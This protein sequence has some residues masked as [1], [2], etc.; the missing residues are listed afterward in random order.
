MKHSVTQVISEKIL[1]WAVKRIEKRKRER[2]D[3]SFPYNLRHLLSKGNT[4]YIMQ[5]C[6]LPSGKHTGYAMRCSLR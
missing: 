4:Y 6:V 5:K 2:K 3:A 1:T